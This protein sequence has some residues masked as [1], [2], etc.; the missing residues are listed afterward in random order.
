M[1]D[2]KR[3][4]TADE[5]RFTPMS[6]DPSAYIG[7]HRRFTSLFLLLAGLAAALFAVFPQKPGSAQ[8]GDGHQRMLRL[9]EQIRARTDVENHYL[10]DA[11][12]RQAESEL[13]ALAADAPDLH[14][15]R[16]NCLTSI[17]DMRLGHTEEA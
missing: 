3:N 14:R 6:S 17:H 8:P 9:I 4:E 1:I 5:R 7:V 16:L 11:G 13:A 12:R 10:G 2:R 15:F